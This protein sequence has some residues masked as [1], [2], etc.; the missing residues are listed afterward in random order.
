MLQAVVQH[1]RALKN[2]SVGALR[3][4]YIQRFGK[5]T[6]IDHGWSLQVEPKA[7]DVLLGRLPWGIGTIRLPWM[8]NMLFT[9]WY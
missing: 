5:L 7:V 6:A 8:K 3:E 9:E 2:S 4:T 1:W